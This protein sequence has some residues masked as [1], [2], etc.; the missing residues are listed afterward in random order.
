[1]KNS[2]RWELFFGIGLI[3]SAALLHFI[4][5]LV[6]GE[7]SPL[8]SFLGK[9][10]AFVPLEV[11]FITLILH[12]LLTL[13]ERNVLKK[14]MNMLSGAFF[15]EVGNDLLTILKNKAS[16]PPEQADILNVNKDWL[17]KDF[18]KACREANRLDIKMELD[19]ASLAELKTLL[20]E[21]R[22]YLMMMLGNPTLIEHES[23]S[24]MLWATI[25]LADELSRRPDLHSLPESDISHL[26]IDASRAYRKMLEE[27]FSHLYHLKQEYPYLYSL[28]MRTNPFDPDS[29]VIINQS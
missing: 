3:V 28:E 2:V 12:R 29:R 26:K 13:H 22:Q 25:H 17:K 18:D 16:M 8:L 10:I 24:D 11:L 27:W 4:H 9:K 21:K 15:S 19:A 7:V 14:K 1:M 6:F 23:F 5:Y 20:V